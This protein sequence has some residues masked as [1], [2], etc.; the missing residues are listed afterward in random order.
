MGGLG[1][2]VGLGAMLLS[3]SRVLFGFVMPAV[4]MVMRRRPMMMCGSP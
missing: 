1:M 3:C 2:L 4:L